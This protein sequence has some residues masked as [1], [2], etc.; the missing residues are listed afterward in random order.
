MIRPPGRS[1]VAFSEAVDGDLRGDEEARAA[2]AAQLGLT[3][4]WAG[5]V[6]VHGNVVVRVD[7]PGCSQEADALW[8]TVAGL[9]LA[10]YTADCYGVVL[11]APSAVGVAHAG[12][13][14]VASGVVSALRED[15]TA[16]G[17][18][19][20]SAILGPGIGP[21]CFEVGPEVADRFPRH[22]AETT[23]GTPS[24]DLGGAILDQLPGVEFWVA[25]GCTHHQSGWFSHRK[26]GTA[27]RMA[28]IGWLREG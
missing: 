17:H 11:V 2:A 19:P 25:P 1:G 16:G 10:V 12:W 5:V 20:Q 4:S 28:T 14:G 7:G 9:P 26:T 21:C 24:V 15:M 8:T 23:W 3:Q 27:E 13:R 18:P 22:T 6:Q